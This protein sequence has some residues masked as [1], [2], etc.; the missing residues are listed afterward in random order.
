MEDDVCQPQ[1]GKIAPVNVRQNALITVIMQDHVLFVVPT[2]R[3]MIISV[4]YVELL[5]MLESTLLSDFR[6]NA[7]SI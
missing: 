3:T 2:D 7:V 4:N 6:G 1:M 5:V